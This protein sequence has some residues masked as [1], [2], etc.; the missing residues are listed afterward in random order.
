MLSVSDVKSRRNHNGSTFIG[1]NGTRSTNGLIR[2]PDLNNPRYKAEKAPSEV[3]MLIGTINDTQ[4]AL[5]ASAT[6][7]RHSDT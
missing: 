6:K 4:I 5:S 1:N 2:G 3:G 7:N